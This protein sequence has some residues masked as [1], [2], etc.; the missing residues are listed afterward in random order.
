MWYSK[1]GDTLVQAITNV[2]SLADITKHYMVTMD[3]DK[4]KAMTIHLPDNPVKFIEMENRFYARL[5]NYLNNKT[6]ISW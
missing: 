1:S 2:I 5:P 4:E 6:F 3:T